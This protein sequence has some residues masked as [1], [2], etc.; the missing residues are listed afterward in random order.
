M[1]TLLISVRFHD[2]RYHGMGDWPPSP[3]R[4]FQALVAGAARG[5]NLSRDAVQAFEWLEGLDAPAISAPSA[6]AGQGFKNYVPN[7]DLDAVGG[8]PSRI[9]EIRVGKVIRPRTFD[10]EVPLIYAWTFEHDVDAERKAHAICEIAGNLYQLGRSVDMACAQGQVVSESDVDA[11]L[12]VH[13]GVLW[14]PN[15]G[16]DGATFSCPQSGSLVSLTKRFSATRERFK[17]IG[18][19]KKASQL[20]SQA[21]KANFRQ[22]PYNSP[23]VFLLFDIRKAGAFAP[24]PIERIAALTERIRNLASERL[25]ASGWR[26][27]D[28]KRKDCIEK[29]LVGRA[30]NEVDKTLRVRITPL[31][32]IGHPRTERSIRRVLVTVPPD[33]PIAADDIAWTFSGL[34]LDFDSESGEVPDDSTTLATADAAPGTRRSEGRRRA[35]ARADD[36]GIS[37]AP[38]IAS[39]GHRGIGA[40]GPGAA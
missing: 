11:R 28:S 9:N 25:T 33:S 2:G 8:N 6:Y 39:R 19:G 38:G 4:L 5:G 35:F 27:D 22:V 23:S 21:P 36:G 18:Y 15:R 30:S 14:R 3:A 24:Q 26:R 17:T 12:G 1:P 16:G 29:V 31:P 32:S 40:C 37:P 7:N 34:A 20:F 10:A 13:G